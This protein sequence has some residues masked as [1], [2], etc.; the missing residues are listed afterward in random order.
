MNEHQKYDVLF[1]EGVGFTAKVHQSDDAWH[2]QVRVQDDEGARGR[3]LNFVADNAQGL[4]DR[5]GAL[6]TNLVSVQRKVLELASALSPEPAV[7]PEPR[8]F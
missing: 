4:A 2:A 8:L 5:L 6:S 7:P 1:V 3:V